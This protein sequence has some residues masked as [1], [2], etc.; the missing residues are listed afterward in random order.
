MDVR[1]SKILKQGAPQKG[2]KGILDNNRYGI[3]WVEHGIQMKS[4]AEDTWERDQGSPKDIVYLLIA[5][6]STGSILKALWIEI[7]EADFAVQW[8][9]L[10]RD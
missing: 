9:W 4:W 5:V 1:S 7:Y 8:I 2:L 6:E 10:G 3:A